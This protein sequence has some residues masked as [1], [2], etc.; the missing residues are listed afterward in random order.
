M[1]LK[2]HQGIPQIKW[3]G[4]DL[5]NNYMV[6]DLLGSSLQS[7]R[8]NVRSFSLALILKI[9]IQIINILM[10]LHDKGFVHRDIKPDNFL[11]DLHKSNQIYLI[12]FGL[13]KRYI[14]DN[15]HIK[16][17]NTY[18]LIGSNNYASIN[19][20]K[21]IELSRRDD[22][23]SLFYVMLFLYFGKLEWREERNIEAI[24]KIKSEITENNHTLK[25]SEKIPEVFLTFIKYIRYIEFAE[26]PNYYLII[27]MFK[28]EI[29]VLNTD[30]CS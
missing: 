11:L 30:H 1:Y 19:S 2:G 18:S 28:K 17:K 23:E 6:I 20:H 22:L 9:G 14:N 3:F 16:M 5:H 29:F 24:M 25:D 7:I 10:I 21:R 13:C 26:K 27:E 15:V 8:Q 12:D 4:K